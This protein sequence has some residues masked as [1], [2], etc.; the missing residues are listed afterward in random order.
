M[1]EQRQKKKEIKYGLIL[2]AGKGSRLG[3]ITE[4]KPKALVKIKGDLRVI[5]YLL[6]GFS[7]AGLKKAIIIISYLGDQIKAYL[8]SRAY[9]MEII[10]LKQDLTSYGTAAALKQASS[11]LENKYF[12]LAYGDIVSPAANFQQLI[13][14]AK[15]KPG[16]S[17]MLLN[18]LAEIKKGGLVT[19][20]TEEKSAAKKGA[21]KAKKEA[22]DLYQV[23]EILEKPKLSGG[24]WNSAGLYLFAPEI[25]SW[26]EQIK[27]SPRGEYELTTAL[28]F[29][30]AAGDKLYGLKGDSYCQDIGTPE[31]LNYLRSKLK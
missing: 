10:Y 3:K 15:L 30:A 24:G 20:K 19:F 28:N 5:D 13:K 21:S 4:K 22:L 9:G 14:A 1:A 6:K 25:F 17:I 11:Y 31:D 2:A 23:A 27:P 8:G 7:A 16:S 26:L 12:M 18:W 29:L